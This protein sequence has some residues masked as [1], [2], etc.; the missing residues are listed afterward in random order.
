MAAYTS[1][2]PWSMTARYPGPINLNVCTDMLGFGFQCAL[3]PNISTLVLSVKRTLF[4]KTRGL[5]R[6]NFAN[7]GCQVL[8]RELFLDNLSKAI[9][10]QNFKI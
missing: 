10:V 7:I 2:N 8:F 5:F 6:W 3:R 9:F 1:S 4:Q